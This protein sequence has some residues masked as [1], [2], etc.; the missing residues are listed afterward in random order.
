MAGGTDQI[1][2]SLPDYTRREITFLVQH[3][4]IQHLDDLILRRSMLGMLGCLSADA[5]HELAGVLSNALSWNDEQRS[6]EVAR[7]L[8]ILADRHGVRL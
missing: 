7:T 4:K 1:L 3:E 5:I 2:R 6:A 8:S